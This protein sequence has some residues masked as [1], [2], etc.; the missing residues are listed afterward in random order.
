[1]S[2]RH[3]D[4]NSLLQ[5]QL[6]RL[7]CRIRVKTFRAEIFVETVGQRDQTHSLMVRHERANQNR[8]LTFGQSPGG[9][10]D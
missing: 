3:A 2:S 5:Q 9:V 1:M 7:H 8:L 10:I 4:G 6:G